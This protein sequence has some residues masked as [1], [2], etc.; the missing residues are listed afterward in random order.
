MQLPPWARVSDARRAHIERVA[1]LA[2]G[3]AT[4]M[5]VPLME[6]GRLLRAVNLH[7]AL[8]DAPDDVLV[9][10]SDD[11]WGIP[12]LRHGPAAAQMAQRHG[13][14]DRGVLDAVRFHSVGFKGW[15]LV[16]KLL[17][18]ADALEPGRSHRRDI[19]SVITASVPR[20]VGSALRAI[21]AERIAFLTAAG[22]RLLPE[23]VGFWNSLLCDA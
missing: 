4:A 1:I 6:R 18:L 19:H 9:T 15:D 23:T 22:M 16:G 11:S 14:R 13:E 2:D 5:R 3:W 17:Y 10:L 8:K 7:D 12:E 21:A 20:D